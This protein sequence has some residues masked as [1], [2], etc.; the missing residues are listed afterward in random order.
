MNSW[1]Y[2]GVTTHVNLEY[3]KPRVHTPIISVQVINITCKCGGSCENE[4]GSTMIEHTDVSVQC[5]SCGKHYN[6]PT[7]MFTRNF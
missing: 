5:S 2:Q 7:S 6:V 4:A 3:R 1:S